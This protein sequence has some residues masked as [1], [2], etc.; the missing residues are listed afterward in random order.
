MYF[1]YIDRCNKSI[2]LKFTAFSAI[3]YYNIIT[4]PLQCV[5][6]FK[7]NIKLTSGS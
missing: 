2:K 5:L 4:I 6:S 3:S 7:Y 1:D